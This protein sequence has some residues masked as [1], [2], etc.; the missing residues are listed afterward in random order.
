[1]RPA[2][3][4][5]RSSV[6]PD[7]GALDDLLAR[8]HAGALDAEACDRCV[9]L[10]PA[11]PGRLRDVAEMLA[12]QRSAPAVE[13]LL[14]LPVRTPGV[15]EG[16]FQAIAHGVARVREDG[17][18]F[19]RRLALDFRHARARDFSQLLAR[20]HAAAT[21]EPGGA[22]HFERLTVDERPHYRLRIRPGTWPAGL[23]GDVQWLH[24]RLV[25][26]RG[27]RLWLNGWCFPQDGP[28]RGPAQTHLVDAWLD[29]ARAQLAK[30]EAAR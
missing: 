19:E 5:A 23:A 15:I 29:W 22:V 21:H 8:G 17:R 1:M 30:H 2:V 18:A 10:T 24:R 4:V 12:A 14:R 27:T 20:A 3:V 28:V 26:L 16:V 9:T 6:S 25:R 11:A 7:L 13:A